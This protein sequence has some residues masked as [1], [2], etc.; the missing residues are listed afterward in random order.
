MFY[1]PSYIDSFDTM[2]GDSIECIIPAEET[3]IKRGREVSRRSMSCAEKRKYKKF[4]KGE[5]GDI[6]R[7]KYTKAI[8]LM[9]K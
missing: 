3:F 5:L 7:V 9:Y 1:T 2:Y 8:K 6:M 4:W